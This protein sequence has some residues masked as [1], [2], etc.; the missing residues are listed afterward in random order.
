[1]SVKINLEIITQEKH[2]LSEVV[3]MVSAPTA[4]GEVTI[5]PHH[6]SLFT[7]LDAGE[8]RYQKAGK[9]VSFVVSGGFME[10]S[11]GNKITV[12]ADSAISSSEINIAKA[13]AAKKR[14]EELLKE[15]TST[16]DML[17]A[18]AELRRALM[19]IKVARK[20]K[21]N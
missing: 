7:K 21:S 3:D 10:V 12:L 11:G 16:R 1:M 4:S 17:L 8:I 13:E 20:R 14:A 18:E 15:K 9:E 6:I 5:L 19:E 2:L